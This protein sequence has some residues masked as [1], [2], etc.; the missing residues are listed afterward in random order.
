MKINSLTTLLLIPAIVIVV[1]CAPMPRS[2]TTHDLR[3]DFDG[4]GCPIGA[5]SGVEGYVGDRIRFYSSPVGNPFTVTFDPFIGRRYQS[6]SADEDVTSP[7]I[8][9]TSLPPKSGSDEETVVFKF[10][11]HALNCPSLDP[12]VIVRH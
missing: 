8:N 9:P 12:Q 2:P 6:R 1:G 3:L 10:S 4:A 7:P 5:Q 11:V